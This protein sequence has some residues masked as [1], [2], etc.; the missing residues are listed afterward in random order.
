M[1]N[2]MNTKSYCGIS[3]MLFSVVALAHL[4]RLINGWM[5]QIDD[6]TIPMLVSWVGL[7]GPGFLAVWGF[8]SFRDAS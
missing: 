7:A 8:R 2:A 5:I 6:M 3:A 1:G 4:T